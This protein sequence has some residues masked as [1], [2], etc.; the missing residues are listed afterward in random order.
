MN[1]LLYSTDEETGKRKFSGKKLFGL[2]AA[3]LIAA[4]FIQKGLGYGP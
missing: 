3:G 2:G 4:P 1:P